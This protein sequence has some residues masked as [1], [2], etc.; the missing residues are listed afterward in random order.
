MQ[1][2][3]QVFKERQACTLKALRELQDFLDQGVAYGIAAHPAIRAKLDN[4]VRGAAN[5]KLR[6]SLVGG[7]SEGKTAIAAAWLERLDKATMKISQQ[8][9]SN[10]VTV[11]DAGD[12]ELV[13][14]P[15]LFGFKEEVDVETGAVEKYKEMTRKFVSESH[16]VIY[17]MDP[18]NP[19]KDSHR[20][21]LNWLFRKLDLLPR[22]VFVLSRFDAVA[23]VILQIALSSVEYVRGF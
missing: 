14:T 13:D 2:T 15:G 12:C 21:E 1:Q 18:A 10:A 23:D 16:L 19:V 8:E 9:S 3:M 22:T 7:F 5:G 20:D 17:V 11:Y 6:V 4:A